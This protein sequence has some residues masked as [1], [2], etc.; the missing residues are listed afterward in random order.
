MSPI[1]DDPTRPVD[2]T[3]IITQDNIDD[4][5]DEPLQLQSKRTRTQVDKF[6]YPTTYNQSRATHKSRRSQVNSAQYDA[7]VQDPIIAA[8]MRTELVDLLIP[9]DDNR[10]S[11][12]SIVRSLA[13]A[14]IITNTWATKKSMTPTETLIEPCP[15]FVLM[16]SDRFLMWT[17]IRTPLKLQHYDRAWHIF[18]PN[19]SHP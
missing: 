3:I 16:V 19:L 7:A 4:F 8:S 14:H 18:T 5:L 12:V 11:K 1:P 17:L 13:R 2:D 6:T 15:V 10:G 9:Q